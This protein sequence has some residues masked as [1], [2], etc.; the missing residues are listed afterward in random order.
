M[1]SIV[2]I[3]LFGRNLLSNVS[4]AEINTG[5]LWD[6]FERKKLTDVSQILTQSAV[7]LTVN[8]NLS[9]AHSYK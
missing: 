2:T 9:M 5:S 8:A 7:Q 1:L 3:L 6:K 4:N